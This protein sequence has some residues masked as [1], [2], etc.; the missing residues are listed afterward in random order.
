MSNDSKE[1]KINLAGWSGCGAFRGAKQALLGLQTI[2]PKD[3]II[4]VTECKDYTD[5]SHS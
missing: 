3:Y 5:S 2:F 4:N 1:K